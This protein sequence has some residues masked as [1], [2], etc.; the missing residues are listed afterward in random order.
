MPRSVR[1]RASCKHSF[2]TNLV[3]TNQEAER[4]RATDFTYEEVGFTRADVMPDGY[5]A[6]T[7]S[8]ALGCGRERF[9]QAV[10]VLFAWDMHRRVGLCGSPRIVEGFLMRLPGEGPRWSRS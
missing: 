7:R 3:L 8:H 9:D 10:E 5:T 2:V 4:L 1:V 6:L